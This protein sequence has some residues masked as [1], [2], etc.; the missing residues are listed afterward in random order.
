MIFGIV[1]LIVGISGILI[2]ISIAVR[3]RRPKRIVYDIGADRRIITSNAYQSTGALV[4]MYGER[5]LRDPYLV[6]VRVANGGKVEVRPEDWQ[7]PFTLK[8]NSEI[9]DSGV[10]GRSSNDL[11]VEITHR[12]AR[13]I[14]CD[15]VLLNQ[16]EWFDIQVLIDGP[17][18]ISDVSA[19]IA[20]A[21]LEPARRSKADRR[22]IILGS[23]YRKAITFYAGTPIAVTGLALLFFNLVYSPLQPVKEPPMTRAPQLIGRPVSQVVPDLHRAKL[24]L[25]SEQFVPS[26]GPVGIVVDQDPG[27]GV[28]LQVGAQVSIVV[29]QRS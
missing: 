21:R 10:V 23:P 14:C 7:E 20:G 16:H 25:G 28:R 1:G 24:H 15:K 4:V 8:T 19:R 17:G 2:T 18:G 22:W 6:V 26:P 13:K 12:E 27:V 9:I 11:S 3:Q 5:Q 29:A